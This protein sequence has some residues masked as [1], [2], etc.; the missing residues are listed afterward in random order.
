MSLF[1]A[2]NVVCC[3]TAIRLESGAK[4]KWLARPQNVADETRRRHCGSALQRNRLWLTI[5]DDADL[6]DLDAQP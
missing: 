2:L 3:E 1:T 6:S 5:A 4:R